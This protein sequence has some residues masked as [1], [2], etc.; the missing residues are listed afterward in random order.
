MSTLTMPTRSRPFGG[1]FAPSPAA[2]PGLVARLRAAWGVRRSRQA[3]ARLDAAALRDIGLEPDAAAAEAA[4][5]LWDV[6]QTW[7]R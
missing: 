6:P 4:R 7:L 3:L 2:R 5:P 1:L